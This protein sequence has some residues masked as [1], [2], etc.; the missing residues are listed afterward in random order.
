VDPFRRGAAAGRRPRVMELFGLIKAPDPSSTHKRMSNFGRV[1][2]PGGLRGF[3][4]PSDHARPNLKFG[5]RIYHGERH[6]TGVGGQRLQLSQVRRRRLRTDVPVGRYDLT[7]PALEGDEVTKAEFG[8]KWM[9]GRDAYGAGTPRSDCPYQPGSEEYR[10]WIWGWDE[11]A[12]SKMEDH[13]VDLTGIRPEQARDLIREHGND[14]QTLE[15]QAH[16]LPP[17]SPRSACN[18]DQQ[19][20]STARRQSGP[21]QHYRRMGQYSGG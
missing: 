10:S 4:W 3:R 21:D 2:Q 8:S 18:R 1:Q 15:R 13:L 16:R 9:E 6:Q 7:S 12:K 11:V 20:C 19:S 5:Q 17:N 14:R